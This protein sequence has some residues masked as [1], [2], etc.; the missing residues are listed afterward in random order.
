LFPSV[1]LPTDTAAWWQSA[2]R[3]QAWWDSWFTRYSA[4]A[5]YHADLA[6]KSGAQALILGG[7]WVAPALPGGQ[8]NGAAMDRYCGQF[9]I[10]AACRPSRTL[11]KH[12]TAFTCCGT[13][14]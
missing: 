3:D 10:Q 12:W 7:D 6:A 14:H 13:R 11:P 9:P 2:P 8:V 4:F 5:V 1:N